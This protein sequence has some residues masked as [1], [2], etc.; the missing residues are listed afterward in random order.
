MDDLISLICM[1]YITSIHSISSI[2]GE[3]GHTID[4]PVLYVF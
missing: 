3:T 4:I 2:L 1:H